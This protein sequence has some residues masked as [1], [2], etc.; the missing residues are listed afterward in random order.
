M[1]S[2]KLTIG[3]ITTPSGAPVPS[4]TI[5]GV[6]AGSVT[7]GGTTNNGN[8]KLAAD[9]MTFSEA[10]SGKGALELEQATA[11]TDINI[12]KSG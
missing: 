3:T 4:R 9:E 6:K 7:S 11:G 10:V 1:K 8:I 5:S 12:G 2:N